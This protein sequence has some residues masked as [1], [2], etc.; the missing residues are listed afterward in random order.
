M[1]RKANRKWAQRLARYRA[2]D[3]HLRERYR[4][5]FGRHRQFTVYVDRWLP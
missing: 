2:G 4:R 5:L 1:G 3:S